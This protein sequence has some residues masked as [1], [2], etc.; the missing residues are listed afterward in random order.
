[1][2]ML[3][4]ASIAGRALGALRGTYSATLPTTIPDYCVPA[5]HT[6]VDCTL[7][8][9]AA[10]YTFCMSI[11]KRF[12]MTWWQVGIFKLSLLCVGIAIGAYWSEAIMPYIIPILVVGIASGLYI[13]Y[14]WAQE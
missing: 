4:L 11:F 3:A 9:A 1:M 6:S 2:H 5:S 7:A 12:A 13:W 10:R 14:V 8:R